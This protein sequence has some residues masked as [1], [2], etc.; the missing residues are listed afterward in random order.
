[1]RELFPNIRDRARATWILNA[2]SNTDR[3][4]PEL[5]LRAFAG[6]AA[7]H[8]EAMLVLHCRAARPGLDLRIERDRLGLRDS[9]ILTEQ[10]RQ[11]PY[12]EARLGALYSACELGVN[13]ASAEGWGLA[14]FEHALHGAAQ[15]LPAHATLHEIWGTAPAWVATGGEVLI[16]QAFSGNEACVE[17]L[18]GAMRA[19]LECPERR[20]AV[21]DACALRA[22]SPH[23][24][25][26][27][28][29]LRW[30][31]LLGRVAVSVPPRGS[32]I[33]GIPRWEAVHP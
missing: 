8:P 27:A 9:V 5:T 23:Y 1:R 22:A 28:V 24:Q 21:A 2:N 6:I 13:S 17:A 10:E 26:D 7:E 18:S 20:V 11:G 32:T 4:R 3:K 30:R 25:W 31:E 12:D 15:I 33:P 14:A 19:L 29:G 16:D